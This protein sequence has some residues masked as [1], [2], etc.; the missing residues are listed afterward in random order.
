MAFFE[1][2]GDTRRC[3]P[4]HFRAL[5]HSCM[6]WG[7]ILLGYFCWPDDTSLEQHSHKYFGRGHVQT[8]S[9]VFFVLQQHYNPTVLVLRQ[10]GLH[11]GQNWSECLNVCEF[12][13]SPR[14]NWASICFLFLLKLVFW[15]TSQSTHLLWP[16]LTTDNC[17]PRNPQIACIHLIK[18]PG[19]H[20]S[21]SMRV[22][23][24][25]SC[26]SA[27]AKMSDTL[28][29]SQ[30]FFYHKCSILLLRVLLGTNVH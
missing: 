2:C 9:F 4:S 14:M 5:W 7:R 27:D 11:V 13:C 10:K 12:T 30:N 16:L 17:T 26:S 25:T 19:E 3:A 23:S 29:A 1:L 6:L 18:Y 24:C 22:S 15:S 20:S 21:S 8:N 28:F